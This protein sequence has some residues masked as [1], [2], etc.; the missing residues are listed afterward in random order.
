MTDS[1]HQ[2][3]DPLDT[4]WDDAEP[5]AAA[6]IQS[7]PPAA[8]LEQIDAG[9]DAS[10]LDG[11]KAADSNA[12]TSSELVQQRNQKNLSKKDRRALERQ[13]RAH[14]ASRDLENRLHRKEA[15]RELAKQRTAD[16]DHQHD[17][18]RQQ[19]LERKRQQATRR[20]DSKPTKPAPKPASADVLEP[21]TQ[22]APS[23][24][25]ATPNRA[26]RRRKSRGA[27][28]VELANV[29]RP[30]ATV[31]ARKPA[32]GTFVLFIGVVFV[33]STLSYFLIR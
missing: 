25:G 14:Q 29:S 11:G 26:E 31:P 16:Q 30:A 13:A 22:S 18:L 24:N 10:E 1:T 33:L 20:T 12:R 3:N 27:S 6:T 21:A 9:W 19:E 17:L 2:V 5:A 32:V 23:P 8:D 15:R 28:T 7:L 4:G